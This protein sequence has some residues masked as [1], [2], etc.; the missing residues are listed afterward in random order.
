[1]ITSSECVPPRNFIPAGK[2]QAAKIVPVPEFAKIKR[3]TGTR[4]EGVR[5]ERKM[6]D[7]FLAR[8][9]D[10]VPG[11][12]IKFISEGKIRWCQPDGVHFN[13]MQ[14]VITVVEFKLQHTSDAWWQ[15]KLLYAPV[16]QKLFPEQL[17]QF[18]FLEVVRWYNPDVKFPE[19]VRLVRDPFQRESAFKI[20]IGNL[21][22]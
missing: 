20:H 1:M 10:Y 17:W 18:E 4:A 2:I 6:Q 22:E 9:P 19:P 21:H 13:L 14:G 12:W 11:F 3:Y 7:S 5:F 15:T 8:F 16:L